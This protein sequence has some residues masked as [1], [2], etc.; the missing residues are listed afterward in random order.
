MFSNEYGRFDL[1]MD[2]PTELTLIVDLAG[3][4]E[5]LLKKYKFNSI[6]ELDAYLDIKKV[7]Q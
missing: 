3:E 7:L 6:E 4:C 1:E 5:R 2:V